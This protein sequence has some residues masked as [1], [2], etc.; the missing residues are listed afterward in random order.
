MDYKMTVEIPI[1]GAPDYLPI[2]EVKVKAEIWL[3]SL[4]SD[5]DLIDFQEAEDGL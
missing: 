2:Q 1:T 3:K 5:A 4:I